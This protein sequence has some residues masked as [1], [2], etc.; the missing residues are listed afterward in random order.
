MS[1]LTTDE[2]IGTLQNCL[3][4]DSA[5]LDAMCPP[6]SLR[7][8]LVE[9]ARLEA[10][11]AAAREAA[12]KWRCFHCDATFTV[13]QRKY[14]RE[15][16]GRDQGDTPVCMMRVPGEHHLIT[17]LR[18]AQDELALYRSEDSD[19][20]RS[21]AAINAEHTEKL[22]REEERGYARGLKDYTALESDRDALRAR[23]A[24]AREVIRPFAEHAA[25]IADSWADEDARAVAIGDIRRA[26][27]F[28][29]QLAG[30][31]EEHNATA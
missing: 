29:S 26:A 28:L 21:I 25:N 22:R 24:E 2:A 27:A 1:E 16:F 5:D 6:I 13:H 23:L 19:L 12:P 4:R 17:A 30:M 9:I 15:H 18:K 20:L 14:A 7:R 31:K 3:D 8:V 11:L 10:D